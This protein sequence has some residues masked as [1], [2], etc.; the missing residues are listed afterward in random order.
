MILFGECFLRIHVSGLRIG[1]IFTQSV[2]VYMCVIVAFAPFFVSY[3]LDWFTFV[4]HS[5]FHSVCEF[6]VHSVYMCFEN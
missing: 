3:S 4:F 2:F 5:P 1:V 6:H